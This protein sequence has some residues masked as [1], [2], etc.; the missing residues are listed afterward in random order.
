MFFSCFFFRTQELFWA[1][2][3][4]ILHEGAHLLVCILLKEKPKEISLGVFGAVLKTEYVE[5]SQKKLIISASGPLFSFVLFIYLWA[6]QIIFHI[7]SYSFN[8]FA[9]SNLAI[10][11]I[12]LLPLSPLDGGAMLKASFM[13]LWGIIGGCRIYMIFSTLFC[14]LFVCCNLY[15]FT[16]GIFNPSLFLILVFSLWGVKHEKMCTLREKRRV[17]TGDIAPKKR[18]KLLFC[19]CESELLCLAEHIGGDYTLIIA[20]FCGERF[21]GEINQFEITDGIKKYGALCT[22]REYIEKRLLQ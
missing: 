10:A 14:F 5:S 7:K 1:Y 9:L 6:A 2:L 13:R 4:T 17:L 15:L 3:A 19:D 22:V 11:L 12:N 21:F 8:F 20:A 18:L 16:L